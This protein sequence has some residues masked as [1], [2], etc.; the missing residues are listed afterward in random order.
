MC[1]INRPG[2]WKRVP[3]FN[4]TLQLAVSVAEKILNYTDFFALI[5]KLVGSLNHS[6]NFTKEFHDIQKEHFPRD[7]PLDLFQYC[8]T[9]WNSRHLMLERILLLKDPLIE[10]TDGANTIKE[11]TTSDWRKVTAYVNVFKALKEATKLMEGDSYVTL[12][13]YIPII[14]GLKNIL[15]SNS[16]SSETEEELYNVLKESVLERFDFAKKDELLITAM[17]VDPRFKVY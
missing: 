16:E 10:L 15:E 14:E 1:A 17:M 4:H 6:T 13:L 5:N 12:S 8:P 7:E 3:C 2:V 9:R 11:L